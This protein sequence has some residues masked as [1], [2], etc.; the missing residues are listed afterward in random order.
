M[1]NRINFIGGIYMTY[2]AYIQHRNDGV[3]RFEIMRD[4]K[5]IDHCLVWREA[6]EDRKKYFSDHYK[7]IVFYEYK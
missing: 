1:D 7:G 2:T 6:I 4:K 5:T 3:L